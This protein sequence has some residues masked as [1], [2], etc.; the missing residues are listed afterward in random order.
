VGS[1]YRNFDQTT[2]DEVRALLSR[3]QRNAR[4][5]LK[6]VI[7]AKLHVTFRPSNEMGMTNRYH[8]AVAMLAGSLA[9]SQGPADQ[10]QSADTLARQVVTNEVKTKDDSYWMYLQTTTKAGMTETA[11][12]IETKAGDLRRLLA[13]NGRPLTADQQRTEDEGMEKFI[14]DA[15][16]QRKQLQAADEDSHKITNLLTLATD[17]LAFRDAGQGADT[18]KL[19]FQPNPA[20]HPLSREA[21][22]LH[23]MA[24]EVTI[25]K[26]NKRLLE[27]TGHLLHEVRF[28]GGVLGHLDQ[29]GT[30]DVRQEEV[31]PNHWEVTLLKVSMKGK[32][33]FFK[34]ISVQQDETRS[35]FQRVPDALTLSEAVE[36]LRKQ[37]AV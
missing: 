23:E 19:D 24:G 36:L 31:A 14:N 2:D 37:H 17:A 8:I 6:M 5:V 26:T 16:Q 20:F 35:H 29:G 28:G 10:E 22:V 4:I 33:L 18:I 3:A 11:E 27:I 25:D 7:F 1:F 34:T 21:H 32:A 13:R 30:F 12:V 15:E 9:F